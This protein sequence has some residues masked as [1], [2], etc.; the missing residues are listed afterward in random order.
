MEISKISMTHE[1]HR[2][3]NVSHNEEKNNAEEVTFPNCKATTPKHEF[4]SEF[5]SNRD[6]SSTRGKQGTK[7][8]SPDDQL[9]TQSTESANSHETQPNNLVDV[10]TIYPESI[11]KGQDY[12]QFNRHNASTVSKIRKQNGNNEKH[13]DSSV[14]KTTGSTIVSPGNVQNEDETGDASISIHTQKQI[15]TDINELDMVQ[16]SDCESEAHLE[17]VSSTRNITVS[18]EFDKQAHLDRE[19]SS[20]VQKRHQRAGHHTAKIAEPQIIQTQQRQDAMKVIPNSSGAHVQLAAGPLTEMVRH[21]AVQSGQCCYEGKAG[22]ETYSQY[23]QR[24]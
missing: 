20:T 1:T 12:A 16:K 24:R 7:T 5:Q 17:Q 11:S 8:I 10:P 22:T 4:A 6:N 14:D 18:D 9:E 21:N 2:S 3:R 13:N 19:N 23:R 15:S